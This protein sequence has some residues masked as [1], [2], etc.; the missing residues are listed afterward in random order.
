MAET[1]EP[2]AAS[3]SVYYRHT[4]SVP[5]ASR[6]SHH[7]RKKIFRKFLDEFE[8]AEAMY[9]L[10]VG[11]TSDS[12]Q[13]ESNYFEKMYPYPN[14]ITC[15]G[16]E[17][18]SHLTR[19]YPGLRYEQVVAGQPLPF[20]DHAFDIVFSNAVLEHVGS[21]NEQAAFLREIMR[22]GK[23]FFVTTPNRW[24]PVEHHTGLPL[25][26][27]LPA[28]L[29]RATIRHTRYKY[30]AAESNLNILTAGGLKRLFPSHVA[31]AVETVR[32]CGFG[33]NLIAFGRSVIDSPGGPF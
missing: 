32:F 3:N 17:D 20:E 26:H 29:F 22:V 15:V 33:S 4:K 31:V 1:D 19:Q 28:S 11:V 25:L 30:W 12:M 9:V 14:R 6:I 13:A 18:G 27:F 21:R 2:V 24:F 10:D 7:I 5:L 16:T 8:P 23:A